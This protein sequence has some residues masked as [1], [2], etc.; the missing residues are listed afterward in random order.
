MPACLA[1]F[2]RQE[3]DGTL[4]LIVIDDGSTDGTADFLS[5]YDPGVPFVFLT[6]PNAGAATARNSGLP[7]VSAPLVLLI[8]ADA[9]GD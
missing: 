4:E 9:G 7:F 6:Q 3:L 2:A 1:A 8:G 5:Q